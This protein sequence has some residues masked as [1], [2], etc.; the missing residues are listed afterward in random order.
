MAKI[1][2]KQ[3]IKAIVPSISVDKQLKA[4]QFL[5][6]YWKIYTQNYKSNNSINGR[7]FES[8]VAI[9]LIR[10]NIFPFYM[11]AKA[12]FIPNVN[13]DFI[14]YTKKVGP[15]SLSLKTSLRERYKQA[16]LEAIALKYVHRSAKTFLVSLDQP[17]VQKL[18]KSPDKLMGIDDVILADHVGYNNILKYI[19][20]NVPALSLKVDIITSNLVITQQNHTTYY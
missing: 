15:I 1:S 8:L 11:Q 5:C 10:E 7:V 14:I 12:A 4:N 6:K 3:I 17:S 13:Y 19:K 16:D 2:T 9:T 20:S 18:K